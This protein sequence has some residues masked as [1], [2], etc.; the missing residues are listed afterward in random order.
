MDINDRF[1]DACSLIIGKEQNKTGIGTLG[2][3]TLH[4]VLKYT[5]EPDA[6]KHEIK[7]ESYC[8]DIKNDKG[9]IEIQTRSFNALRKK[10]AFFLENQVVTIVY[11]IPKRKW[12]I[13]I[14]DK[15]GKT[16]DKRKS[17]KVGKA[18]QPPH[19]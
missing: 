15:T 9:I 19:A 3:K 18:C 7:I 16:T 17:P 10:L 11:P 1:E 6:T 4:V 12:I 14:D 5:F 13:W 8:A 2:E